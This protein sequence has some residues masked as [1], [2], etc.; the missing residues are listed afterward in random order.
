MSEIP[1]VVFLPLA[2]YIVVLSA[3]SCVGFVVLA[4]SA[5]FFVCRFFVVFVFVLSLV[6]AGVVFFLFFENGKRI[7]FLI[8][9]CIWAN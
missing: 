7:K 1:S 6:T 9:I 3:G 8:S 5:S 4:F 2:S